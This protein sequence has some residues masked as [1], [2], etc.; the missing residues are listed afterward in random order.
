MLRGEIVRSLG[1]VNLE[2]VH[3]GILLRKALKDWLDGLARRAPTSSEIY[4]LQANVSLEART[5]E[6]TNIYREFVG[7]TS[8]LVELCLRGDLSNHCEIW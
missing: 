3:I 1:E 8:E 6:N 5:T 4:D 7:I 2:E